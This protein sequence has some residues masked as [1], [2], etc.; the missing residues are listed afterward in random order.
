M[1][2]LALDVSKNTGWAFYDTDRH[3][4]AIECGVIVVGHDSEKKERTPRQCRDYFDDEVTI[5]HNKYRPDVTMIEEP[6]SYITTGEERPKRK[7]PKKGD[8]FSAPPE[9]KA[10]DD[11]EKK[12]GGPNAKSVL[13]MNQLFAIAETVARHKAPLVD[14]VHPR[15]WQKILPHG[16]ENTK[17][18]SLQ[19]AHIKRVALPEAG[20]TEFRA[21]AS[22]AV[23]I[24][25]WA[26]THSQ[27]V[28][29]AMRWR[30]A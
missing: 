5:L 24:A 7:A 3:Q 15:T 17:K 26:S 19:F 13:S 22:D 23:G 28:K 29:E 11:G 30:A 25:I 9:P 14:T 2:I 16:P 20:S 10:D 4:S 8:L 12:R 6:L 21:N 18:R 27:I 1:R